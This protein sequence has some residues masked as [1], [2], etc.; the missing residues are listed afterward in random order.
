[1]NKWPCC[2]ACPPT[3][4]ECC[5]Q[6]TPL[7]SKDWSFCVRLQDAWRT[8]ILTPSV[9]K[10]IKWII[11]NEFKRQILQYLSMFRIVLGF[12]MLSHCLSTFRLHMPW[13]LDPRDHQPAL[14]ASMAPS[15][16]YS[17]TS[18]AARRCKILLR[19]P[20]RPFL[21]HKSPMKNQTTKVAHWIVQPSEQFS[22]PLASNY[23]RTHF[24]NPV[25]R[26]ATVTRRTGD[27]CWSKRKTSAS[28]FFGS[29]MI[30]V[31]TPQLSKF[32]QLD[33]ADLTHILYHYRQRCILDLELNKL[34]VTRVIQQDLHYT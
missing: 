3:L 34:V 23:G 14:G 33:A 11:N 1:M 16:G 21:G 10:Q 20:F 24:A 4:R 32:L 31:L 27:K 25:A 5:E 19:L 30:G 29:A 2:T 13:T 26:D 22:Q 12:R 6:L 8:G 28:A 7:L 18:A 9:S 17:K 15:T